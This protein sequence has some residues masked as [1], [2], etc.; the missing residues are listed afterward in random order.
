MSLKFKSIATFATA[1]LLSLTMFSTSALASAGYPNP[2]R[3]SV[4][5]PYAA[6][7]Y[8]IDS[9]AVSPGATKQTIGQGIKPYGLVYALLKAKVEVHWVI[10]PAK[11]AIDQVNGNAGTDF[12]FDCDGA[13][14]A[15]A[16]KAYR[17]GA[18]VVPKEFGAQAK[19]IIDSWKANSANAG[20]VV[21]GPCSAELPEL[22]IF[23]KISSWPRT[24]LDA[25]NG[26]VAVA[27]YNNAGIA[28]GS[29]TDA[30]VPPAYR[31]A[32][33]SQLTACD[34]FYVMPHADPTY[35]T[36]KELKTFVLAG[37]SFY[38]SCHAVS[39]VENMVDPTIAGG[40]TKYMNFLSSNGLVNY[41]A[42]VQGSAPYNF[43]KTST[44][45]AFKGSNDGITLTD[46]EGVRSGDPIAQFLGVTTAATQQGSE[47]IFIPK[48]G[49]YW[50]PTTQIIQYDSTQTNASAT[51]GPATSLAYGPAF[52]DTTGTNGY[53]M[54][55]GGHSLNKGSVDDVAAQR[56]F[57]NM[58][59]LT[60]V[61][62]R[63][64]NSLNRSRSPIVKVTEP[65]AGVTISGGASVPVSGN[66]TGGS[67]SFT[68]K[69]TAACY[70]LS[71]TAI[72]GGTFANDAV[73]STTFTAP[74][75]SGKVNCNMTLTVVDTCGRFSFG[76]QSV[77]FSPEANLVLNKS[78]SP[79]SASVGALMTYTLTVKNTG[80]TSPTQDGAL[81]TA[82]DVKL[83][84]PLP[85]GL[86]FDSVL[87]PSYSG[88]A[89]TGASCS[90][91]GNIVDCHLKDLLDEQIATVTITAY[92][93]SDQGGLTVKNRATVS[94]ASA[95]SD[96]STNTSE[97]SQLVANEGIKVVVST[98][99]ATVDAS[100][101]S[102]TYTYRVTNVGSN[103]LS[104]VELKDNNGTPG[105]IQDDQVLSSPTGD[106]GVLGSLA[107]GEIWVYT[108]TRTVSSASAD[109]DID[110]SAL[111]KRIVATASGFT[112]ASTRVQSQ[113]DATVR[114]VTPSLSVTKTTDTPKVKS[115]GIGYFT[116]TVK[117]TSN[118]PATFSNVVVSDTYTTGGVLTCKVLGTIV[119]LTSVS[120]TAPAQTFTTTIATLA[121]ND[122]WVA[123]CDISGVTAEGTNVLT[124]T[125]DNP[126]K[127]GTAVVPASNSSVSVALAEPALSV[128]KKASTGSARAGDKFYY[129]VAA[130]NTQ[131]TGNLTNVRLQDTLPAGLTLEGVTRNYVNTRSSVSGATTG[132]VAWEKFFDK[133]SAGTAAG[134]ATSGNSEWQT[135]NVN[136]SSDSWAKFSLS[137]SPSSIQRTV[138]LDK[139]RYPF[140]H[141]NL[142]C[143]SNN[144]NAVTPVVTLTSG[145]TVIT[146]AANSGQSCGYTS[147]STPKTYR[148]INYR[149]STD[150]LA[151]S[152][153]TY[154]LKIAATGAS[155]KIMNLDDIYL[156]SG[157][158]AFDS[159]VS[160]SDGLGWAGNGWALTNPDSKFSISSSQFYLKSESSSTTV[161]GAASRSV[162]V[163]ADEYSS[164]ELSFQCRHSTFA[165]ST[166]WLEIK[167]NG[168]SI[169]REDST[170]TG[171]Q[172]C[173]TSSTS[174]SAIKVPFSARGEVVFTISMSSKNIKV[175]LSDLVVS[176]SKIGTVTETT[177][178]LTLAALNTGYVLTPGQKIEFVISVSVDANYAGPTE[179]INSVSSTCTE[180]TAPSVA[181]AAVTILQAGF[182]IEKS[183][184]KS[185]I[186]P[187][188][189]VTYT[190][191]VRN[192][193]NTSIQDVSIVDTNGAA[194]DINVLLPG[195]VALTPPSTPTLGAGVVKTVGVIDSND[196]ILDPEEV[197]TFTVTSGSLSST[198]I[199]EVTLGG[200]EQVEEDDGTGTGTTIIVPTLLDPVTATATVKV[201]NPALTIATTA[202]SSSTGAPTVSKIYIN[203]TVTYT[204]TVTNTGSAGSTIEGLVV[205]AANC[206]ATEYV[207]GDA[208]SDG[209][210]QNSETWIFT[211]TTAAIATSQVSQEV[212]A[213]GAN[214]ELN[215]TVKS[216]VQSFSVNVYA[217]GAISLSRTV[218]NATNSTTGTL[219]G[220]VQRLS[221]GNTNAVTYSY[222][223][224][225]A[226]STAVSAAA[227]YAGLI[228]DDAC[229]SVAYASGDTGSDLELAP[230]GAETWLFT[231]VAPVNLDLRTISN[232]TASATDIVG[233]QVHSEPKIV[234]ITVLS[235][236]LILK[237]AGADE[238][239][240]YGESNVFT[241]SIENNGGTSITAF[242]P[243]DDSCSPLV[244]SSVTAAEGY[245]ANQ[246]N[247]LDIG[248]IFN[249]SCTRANYTA[250]HMSNFSVSGITDGL[251][252]TGYQADPANTLV[253]V[254]DPT[255]TVAQQATVYAPATFVSTANPGTA[256][257]GPA[258]TVAAD[259]N[260]VIVYTYSIT[261]GAATRGSSV[262]G[263]N[264]ML[265]NNI[266]D[267]HCSPISPVDV[268]ADNVNDGDVNLNGQL[269]P[270][271]T[272]LFNC[273][274]VQVTAAAAVVDAQATV[275]AANVAQ[276]FTI[277]PASVRVTVA[278]A[279][280][281]A[282]PS[283]GSTGGPVVSPT[284]TPTASPSVTPT[285]SVKPKQLT[286]TVYFK[287]DSAKLL[288]AAIGNLKRIAALAKLNG[289]ASTVTIIGRV[290]E[291]ADKSYDLR[292]S[293]QRATN[294]AN[295]L[296]K[297]GVKGTYKTVAAGISPENKA[298]SRRVEVTLKWVAK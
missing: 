60:A 292:L 26:S 3:E 265:I 41:D 76:V 135:T 282:S 56:A 89:P 182:T 6:G 63:P 88:T 9:G 183:V 254:I 152:A 11:P 167:A 245:T 40:A 298:I 273:S 252:Y 132:V 94:S 151:A 103:E 65:A 251:G 154:T 156:N 269:D 130:T 256:I 20:L 222:Q 13:G 121:Q 262:S 129:T 184:S 203:R 253:F 240:K 2:G 144:T 296:K 52:G 45:V 284:P 146:V 59:L 175:Y 10:N 297:L 281:S 119:P 87:T 95:D 278:G 110:S 42:H 128:S 166:D 208:N 35:A 136:Y 147:N 189:S 214:A 286:L 98:S 268:D 38:A 141:I 109:E 131:S 236:S 124:A 105:N 294:V 85:A 90:A 210:I 239:V 134:W 16:S 64:A 126:L 255:M 249:Y 158:I 133:K 178:G 213:T 102:V 186:A 18:F 114:V 176:G 181:S 220:G 206:P 201:V 53:V 205:V 218:A 295:F 198:T 79:S 200:Y 30:A 8:I 100:G 61:D 207:S 17:T 202:T 215:T 113:G 194:T 191:T 49:S 237:V 70:D 170:N 219:T 289:T 55:Q 248:E 155:S 243:A 290:K 157:Q 104:A 68:Y 33:P 235:P 137:S 22:R 193:G 153:T 274:T 165:Q 168:V 150:L 161:T 123:R 173:S 69:W 27:Y 96:P 143:S 272:W 171:A 280:A 83:S 58:V 125:A 270:T 29:T 48:V 247:I 267:A 159:V 192:T 177:T 14:T 73:A 111:T 86:T 31:Y 106:G 4:T 160:S 229:A 112:A 226:G 107:T 77:V 279:A 78:V 71:G 57:F 43:F 101:A 230:L 260:D 127:P 217:P 54:Y 231:C 82:L 263:L 15:Y 195:T 197:W 293:R 21:D 62:R 187:G 188:S 50:R 139:T 80:V 7:A 264:A 120:V 39:V 149:V 74:T 212:Y 234:D 204:F 19:S 163:S 24:T 258:L 46:L 277:R 118:G 99:R 250:D 12:T 224:T 92:V 257:E 169:F 209:S 287:G 232:A 97:V 233:G 190:Y 108:Y 283:P 242:T 142:E 47:Q 275:S 246:D 28:Q 5:T 148:Q 72:S 36:H 66:A 259:L 1:A 179:V 140:M 84:D 225:N 266:T 116:L 23:S 117:N 32:S 145:S 244:R 199:G 34:D 196:N 172:R 227:L 81:H 93:N 67:G 271:E 276:S 174:G 138:S 216:N 238:Y 51:N 221:V 223:V 115:G 75:V 211:C 241:Y 261:S 25:Q 162:V 288:P 91:I 285:P 164:A 44:E 291:T 228:I 185:V 122:E 37:G 180:E